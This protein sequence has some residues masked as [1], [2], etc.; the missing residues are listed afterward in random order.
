MFDDIYFFHQT[1]DFYKHG[2]VSLFISI[3]LIEK[4]GVK[5]AFIITFMLFLAKEIYDMK[6]EFRDITGNYLGF[7]SA[8]IIEKINK[9]CI[10]QTIK[11]FLNYY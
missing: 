4:I 7:I 10:F 6:P 11:N 1:I 5:K 9:I 2:F 3:I 8:I